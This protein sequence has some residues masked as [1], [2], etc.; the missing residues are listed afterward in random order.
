METIK[1]IIIKFLKELIVSYIYIRIIYI[2][3]FCIKLLFLKTVKNCVKNSKFPY[4]L[5]VLVRNGS[6]VANR[7]EYL[8]V[9]EYS[10][11]RAIPQW[12]VYAYHLKV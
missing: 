12:L 6:P 11:A 5:I 8:C 4:C 1:T 10:S 2:D 3:C 9:G 7:A